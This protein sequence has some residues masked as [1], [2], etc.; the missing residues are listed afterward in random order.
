MSELR[1]PLVEALAA[2]IRLLVLDVDGVLTDGGLYYDAN[3]LAMKRLPRSVQF[4]PNLADASHRDVKLPGDVGGPL[5][6][7]QRFGESAT[8]VALGAEPLR[9]IDPEAGLLGHRRAVILDDRLGPVAGGLALL[10]EPFHAE[11]VFLL[12]K[13]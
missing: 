11:S 13:A 4:T 7:R 5:A 12:G 1:P 9:K 10:V 2:K 6:H 8:P 3:G